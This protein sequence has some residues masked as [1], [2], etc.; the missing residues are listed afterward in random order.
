MELFELTKTLMQ[1][2]SPTGEEE[3]A[4]KFLKNYFDASGFVVDLQKV[5]KERY[6]IYAKMGE[7]DI[8]FSTHID[9]VKPLL[10]IKEDKYRIYGRGACDAKGILAAQIKAVERLVHSGWQNIG[11]LIVVGEEGG[12]DGAKV[13]N[14]I[15][16]NCRFLICGE[17]TDNKLAVGTKGALRLELI[18]RGK[19][20]HSAYPELGESAIIRLFDI[21]HGWRELE[22]PD[23]NTLG[24]TTWNIGIIEGGTG[25]N[26]IPDFSRAEMM[27]RLV[28]NV[29]VIK[30]LLEKN[31]TSKD[32]IIYKFETDP[33]RLEPVKGFETT[34]VSFAT[35]IP[36]LSNWGNPYLLGPGS[37]LKAHTM[38]ESILK[39]ELIQAV[40]L[41][42][43]L[44]NEVR[45]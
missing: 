10:A 17:P 45:N 7:P 35:D 19:S 15:E 11:L 38:E 39:K 21:I 6:N 32:E 27:Y 41:Y 37:I 24:E 30:E 2:P 5:E 43:A 36:L 16:N 33:V 44:A 29:S 8:V 25:A 12:S 9:T 13:A 22:Y 1:I 14:Q 40:E 42:C 4:V 31:I 34:V 3:K 18:T 28:T 23:D 20:G 26:V